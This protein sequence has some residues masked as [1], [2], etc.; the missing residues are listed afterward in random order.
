MAG[1]SNMG[2]LR[3]IHPETDWP[4]LAMNYVEGGG[5]I[6]ERLDWK[7][8]PPSFDWSDAIANAKNIIANTWCPLCRG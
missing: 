6:Q 8:S 5:G 7:E 2:N 3:Y 4:L 1:G